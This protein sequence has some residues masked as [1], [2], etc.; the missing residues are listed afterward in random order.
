M[1]RLGGKRHG[2]SGSGW[3]RKGDGRVS[4][5]SWRERGHTLWEF[6]RTDKNQITLKLTDLEKIEEEALSEGRDPRVGIEL[7][8]K[9]YVLMPE[10]DYIEFEEGS[11]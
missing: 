2:G 3:S 11:T 8:G 7:G 9:N 4:K 6:K 1:Q 10:E 5:R